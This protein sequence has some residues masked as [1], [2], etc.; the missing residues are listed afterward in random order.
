MTGRPTTQACQDQSQ[1]ATCR[2][3]SRCR[4]GSACIFV[5]VGGG[6]VGGGYAA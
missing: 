4:V 1:E 5:W 6:G 3:S 2:E